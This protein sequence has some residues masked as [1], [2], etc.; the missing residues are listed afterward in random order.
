MSRPS[1]ALLE[2][3]ARRQDEPGA[4]GAY[5]AAAAVVAALRELEERLAEELRALRD[6]V[7]AP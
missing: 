5:L 1:D 6:T 2:E 4:A 7:G 3:L